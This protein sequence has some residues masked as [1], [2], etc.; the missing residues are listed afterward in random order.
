MQATAGEVERPSQEAYGRIVCVGAF[1]ECCRAADRGADEDRR[2]VGNR[3][4]AGHALHIA[5]DPQERFGEPDVA[6]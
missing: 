2:G 3:A 1:A 5:P 6:P 4:H